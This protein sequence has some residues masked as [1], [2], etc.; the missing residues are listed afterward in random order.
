LLNVTREGTQLS[1]QCFHIIPKPPYDFGLS[2]HV[3]SYE[4]PMPEVYEEGVWRRAI[5]LD[6]GRLIPVELQSIGTI[7]EPKIEVKIFQTVTKQE[8]EE[9]KKKLDE[10]FSFSQDLTAFYAFMDK[11]PILRDLKLK[12]YGLKAGSIG[13]TVFESII[14]SII[15]QQ[16][17]IRVAFSITNK[18]VTRFGEQTEAEE[19][20]YYDFPT[21]KR[22]AEAT[23]E[24]IRQCGVSW[25]KAEY[26][27]GIAD[28]VADAEFDPEAL[29]SLS[30]E[31]VTETLKKFRGVG[32]WTAEMVLSAGLKRN[33]CIPAGDLGVRRT[34][35]RFYSDER[36]L[37]ETEVRKIAEEWR[38]FTK[39]IIYYI[40]CTE[41]V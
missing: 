3:F 2:C 16:I 9:L 4:K 35:S 38:E 32:T 27:K 36:I 15:Q 18:M 29:R 22:L 7:E 13:T 14:K 28:K 24:E 39:D 10:L 37:S 17:S 26:I 5:R 6:S 21:P 23:L 40:S 1:P 41:R 34:F 30:N 31:Q 20:T 11:D 33:A 12:F 25:R 8:E 19:S